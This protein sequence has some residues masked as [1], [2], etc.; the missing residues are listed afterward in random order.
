M[1]KG[2]SYSVVKTLWLL[3]HYMTYRSEVEL[4]PADTIFKDISSGFK[5]LWDDTFVNFGNA[6]HIT[7][8]LTSKILVL[9]MFSDYEYFKAVLKSSLPSTKLIINFL[10]LYHYIYNSIAN[11]N[12]S[13]CYLWLSIP[14]NPVYVAAI[15]IYAKFIPKQ[16]TTTLFWMDQVLAWSSGHVSIAQG[17]GAYAANAQL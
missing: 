10:Y 17:V 13:E 16:K 11:C 1:L 14:F 3:T 5:F 8:I 7:K 4:Y 15:G 9:H 12:K 6:L 2:W